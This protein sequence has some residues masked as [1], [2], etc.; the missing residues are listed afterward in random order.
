MVTQWNCSAKSA[1]N[2]N[3]EELQTKSAKYGNAVELQC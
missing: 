3:A 1:K 2:G